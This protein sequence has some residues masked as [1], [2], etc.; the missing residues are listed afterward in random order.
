MASPKPV[1]TDVDNFPSLTRHP[2]LLTQADNRPVLHEAEVL[3]H[4][5]AYAAVQSPLNAIVQPFGGKQDALIS[6]PQAAKTWSL[7]WNLQQI[8]TGA[9]MLAPIL[10]SRKLVTSAFPSA[11]ADL[12]AQ[13]GLA[14]L[15][16]SELRTLGRYELGVSIG[17]GLAYGGLLT[18][19]KLEP[20]QSLLDARVRQAGAGGTTFGALTL[21]SMGLKNLGQSEMLKGTTLA[22]IL[23]NDTAVM[24][25]SGIPAGIVA[26]D[27]DSVMHGKGLPTLEQHFNSKYLE[28]IYNFSVV[29]AG[30]GRILSPKAGTE[31]EPVQLGLERS[32]SD[33]ALASKPSAELLRELSTRLGGEGKIPDLNLDLAKAPSKISYGRDVKDLPTVKEGADGAATGQSL[34]AFERNNIV[35]KPT[36]VRVYEAEGSSLR[37]LVPEEY[38]LQLDRLAELQKQSEGTGQ[39]AEKARMELSKP[40]M[41]ELAGRMN[42]EDAFRHALMTPEPGKFQEIVLSGEAN[43]YDAWYKSRSGNSQFES[44]ADTVFKTGQ[45]T[46]YRKNKG[47]T[48]VED[49][50]HEWSHHFEEK[51]PLAAQV[52][53]AANRVDNLPTRPYAEVPRERLAILMGE[54]ALHP[55]GKRAVSLI[56]AA[57]VTATA[58]GEGLHGLLTGL[59]PA[60]RGPMHDQLMQRAEMLRTAGRDVARTSLLEQIKADPNSAAAKNAFRALLYLG[61]TADFSGLKMNSINLSYEPIGDTQGKRIAEMLDVHDLDLSYTQIGVETMRALEKLPLQHANLAGTKITSPSL[62]FLPRGIKSVD[63]SGTAIGDQ[64]V[65]FLQ[66][67]QGASSIDVS[68]TKISPSGLGK[69]RASMPGTDIIH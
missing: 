17:T 52:I 4:S 13:K 14:A 38:A 63:L 20:G 7:D 53:Q 30:L 16:S 33:N 57:P 28:S 62:T 41:Q 35:Q 8:G 24:A 32:A 29:G 15:T 67:L 36:P 64:A 43:P 55:D 25:L 54:Y 65:P 49:T 22:K 11:T 3:L 50:M 42:V 26:V 58:I 48:L 51:N 19:G 18:P 23:K 45:T 59:S 34:G 6:A 56:E 69:L 44:A 66:R 27:A 12:A 68:G 61:E 5:A 1:F 21:S 60:E 46:W 31:R 10:L 40:E 2:E 47:E 9:G 39:A 37:V